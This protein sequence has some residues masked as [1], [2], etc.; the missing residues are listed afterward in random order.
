MLLIVPNNGA[1][2]NFENDAMVEI[3]CIVGKDGYEPLTVGEIPHFQKGLMEQQVNCEKLVVDAYEQHSY[4][5]MLQALT[6]NK[7]V[8]NANVARK[9]FKIILLRQIKHL[10]RI[11]I[12]EEIKMKILLCC[13]AGM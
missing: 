4:L 6:L 7:C 2:S 8:P 5:K 3:P 11:K 12:K 1:I 9:I 10:A 13:N